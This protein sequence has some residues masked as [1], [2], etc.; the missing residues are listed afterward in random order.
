MAKRYSVSERAEALA[1]LQANGGNLLRTSKATGIPRKTLRL[2]ADCENKDSDQVLELLPEKIEELATSLDTIA[3]KLVL[4]SNMKLDEIISG[5]SSATIKDLTYSMTNTVQTRNL[6]RGQP[7]NITESR[8]TG[9][10]YEA[11]VNKM[12]EEATKKGFAIDRAEAIE[13]LEV[14]IP[15]IREYVN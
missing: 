13:L 7:T 9:K 11:A 15:D 10:R 8:S 2:W 12:I 14:Q 4:A 3:N 5:K 1:V 6:L